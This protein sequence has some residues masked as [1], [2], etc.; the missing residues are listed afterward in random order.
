MMVIEATTWGVTDNYRG[1]IYN[2]FKAQGIVC[3]ALFQ[4]ATKW[5]S[6]NFNWVLQ[7]LKNS[8]IFLSH[9]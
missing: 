7:K 8:L 6:I 3:V 2:H 5:F 9:L 4:T 1:F